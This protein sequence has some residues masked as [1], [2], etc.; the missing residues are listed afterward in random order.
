MVHALGKARPNS[1]TDPAAATE[2][3]S[4]FSGLALQGSKAGTIQ[5]S[6][7]GNQSSPGIS[8]YSLEVLLLQNVFRPRLYY[9]NLKE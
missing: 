6:E 3:L 7:Q 1:Q 4:A 8:S 2:A 5:E 9:L